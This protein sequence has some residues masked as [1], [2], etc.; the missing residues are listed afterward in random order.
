MRTIFVGDN[1]GKLALSDNHQYLYVAVTAP[2]VS[3]RRIN[4]LTGQ[5]DLSFSVGTNIVAGQLRVDDMEVIPGSPQS[6]VVAR[7]YIG[8]SPRYAETVIFDNGVQRPNTA[9]FG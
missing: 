1:P 4:L 8:I 2:A 3:V 9:P 5:I 6:L 7:M